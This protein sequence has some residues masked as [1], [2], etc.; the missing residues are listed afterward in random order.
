MCLIVLLLLLLS[1]G[2][3][4]TDRES[5][6]TASDSATHQVEEEFTDHDDH[7]ETAEARVTL[8]DTAM[9]TAGIKVDTVSNT[10]S[11]ASR[12]LVVP[13]QVQFDPRRVALVSPRV[14]GRIERLRV[15][16]GDLVRAGET[17]ALLYS[18][19]F[20]TA[21]TDLMQAARRASML[22]QTPDSTGAAALADAAA[23]RLRT[24]GVSDAAISRLTNGGEP[25]EF[26]PLTSPLA[27]TITESHTLPGSAIEAGAP[28]FKVSDLSV[29]DVVA[30][31]PEA[32]LPL[33]ERGLRAEVSIPAYPG[34]SFSGH[35]ERMSGELNPETRTVQAVVHVPNR[36]N[37]L[38]AGMFAT[39]RLAIAGS[40][41]AP[42]SVGDL[43]VP[44]SAIVTEGD[45]SF[46]F[47][48]VG[49]NTFERRSV[50]VGTLT[51]PGSLTPIEGAM[52]VRRGLAAGDRVV[53][54]GAFTLKSE[55]AKASLG[56]HGH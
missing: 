11:A 5:R 54:D 21:Q 18:P 27:G 43:S 38:R 4:S 2:C 29:M 51:P 48:E 26:L 55:L 17:V 52:A 10:I 19:A 9:R 12:S 7:E 46:V 41:A 35:V 45:R 14:P 15:V 39:V 36:G 3:G 32:S 16:Q 50:E 31:V 25:E 56:E 23:R 1:L 49:P 34:M 37:R 40:R 42:L 24:L 22:A 30:E 20:L 8:S 28:V 47:V 33:V 44:A 53:V 6:A 13:G